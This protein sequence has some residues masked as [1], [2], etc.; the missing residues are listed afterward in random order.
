MAY[1]S[2]GKKPME[3]ASKISHAE[4]INNAS[5]RDYLSRCR[6]PQA[7]SAPVLESKTIE[8]EC[9]GEE[10]IKAVIAI[11]GGYTITPVKTEYPFA[12]VAFYTFGPLLF[13]LVHLRELSEK[14]FIEPEDIHRLK[15]IERY[16]FV[17]PVR[18]VC[19]DDEDSLS[20]TIRRTVHDFFV[21]ER[22]PEKERLI[23][24]LR[25]LLFRRWDGEH[26]EHK[27]KLKWCPNPEC[28]QSD[29]EFS[30]EDG[31][32]IE[33]P[34]CKHE[35]FL[36]D[37]LRLHELVDEEQGAEGIVGYVLSVLEQ[38]VLVHLVRTILS[39]KPSLLTEILFVKDGPL[40][41]F[42]VV[43][44]LHLPMRELTNYLL[45]SEKT[46]LRLV[47]VEKSGA[48]VEHALAIQKSMK[49]GSL[50]ICE[51]EYIYRY[52]IPGDS[53]TSL[54]GSST[55][56]GQKVIFRS[57]DGEMYVVTAPGL[58]YEVVPNRENFPGLMENLRVISELRCCMYENALVPI[59]LVNKL[60]SLSDFPSQRILTNFA[61]GE[62]VP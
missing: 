18:G 37:L 50:L 32:S 25:W 39:I 46:S 3:R 47:G 27:E 5:V 48:F 49:K 60:V 19:L 11:D 34:S 6:L 43:A 4:I 23:D 22:G 24:S 9:S 54:Y 1:S 35:V 61:K 44:E 33:C 13:E 40:A 52:I 16:T 8:L 55:Y 62:M 7:A 38:I 12:S 2:N 30:Y 20:G 56:Y 59:A 42:G 36:I 28:T 21:A 26:S 45:S 17:L 14:K 51:N 31:V 53:L 57:E 29:L 15:K 58:A 41:F 10:S